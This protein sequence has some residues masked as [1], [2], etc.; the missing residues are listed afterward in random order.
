MSRVDAACIAV[1]GPVS[2]NASKLTNVA[3]SID[4][5]ALSSQLG[6]QAVQCVIAMHIPALTLRP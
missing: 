4:G 3:W 5:T 1:A 2:N 6:T